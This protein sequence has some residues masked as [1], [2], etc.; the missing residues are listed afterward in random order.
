MSAFLIFHSE[1]RDPEKFQAYAQAVPA[2]LKS[3]GGTLM[4]KGKSA[5]VL[6]GQH[7]HSTV[8]ILKFPDLIKA[9]GWYESEAYQ[10]L[11]PNRN[12]AADMTV[13]SYEQ[14]LA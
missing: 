6:S 12:E 3:F 13:I 8:G 9:H 4:A 14:P 5:K 7:N 1:V 11:I 2:T 10:A